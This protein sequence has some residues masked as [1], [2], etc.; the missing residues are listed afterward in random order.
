MDKRDPNEPK[1]HSP[2]IA[3]VLR[4]AGSDC[5]ACEEK[6][7]AVRKELMDYYERGVGPAEYRADNTLEAIREIVMGPFTGDSDA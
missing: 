2:L 4:L 3:K 7:E 5:P 6:L 1:G